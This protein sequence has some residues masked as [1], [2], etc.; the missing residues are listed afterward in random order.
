MDE[1]YTFRRMLYQGFPNDFFSRDETL[2]EP[3]NPA[4]LLQRR[5]SLHVGILRAADGSDP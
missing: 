2:P 3:V 5:P 4:S 1:F